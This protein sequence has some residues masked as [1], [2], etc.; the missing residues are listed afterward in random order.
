MLDEIKQFCKEDR[1]Y[2]EE[3]DPCGIYL[4]LFG[5]DYGP[6]DTVGL[7]L[8]KSSIASRNAANIG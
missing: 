1:V 5:N 6:D 4:G 3:V 7:Q 2:L 8:T